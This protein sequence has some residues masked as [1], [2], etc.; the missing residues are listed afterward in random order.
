MEYEVIILIS[1]CFVF[2]LQVRRALISAILPS[3]V[4]K[5]QSQI[6]KLANVDFMHINNQFERE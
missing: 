4:V 1:K 3:A 5:L 6:A 2:I